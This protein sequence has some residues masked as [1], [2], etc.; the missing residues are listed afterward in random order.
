MTS[1]AMHMPQKCGKI[2]MAAELAAEL[3]EL[4]MQQT[5]QHQQQFCWTCI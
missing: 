1:I 2:D 4:A 5:V 3:A